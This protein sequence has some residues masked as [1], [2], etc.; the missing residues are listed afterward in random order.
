[1]KERG[2][3]LLSGECK[4]GY[5]IYRT[6]RTPENSYDAVHSRLCAEFPE[7][8]V[9]GLLGHYCSSKK[10]LPSNFDDWKDFFGR[11]YANL[12]VHYLQR[13]LQDS[14]FRSGLIPGVDVLRY[15]FNRRLKC[16]SET[17]PVEL[18]VTHSSDVPIWFWGANFSGGLTEQEKAWLK[19]WNQGFASFV[20]GEKVE[21]GPKQPKEMRWWRSD[22]ETDVWTD[23]RWEE[24]LKIWN[25]PNKS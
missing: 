7:D 6:W 24:G 25:L 4:D 12:Q 5:T 20:K 9:E 18:G 13:G 19:G 17:F 22:G 8:T 2:I 21:W 1:M 3:T 16:V 15:R 11:T 10:Q 23:D 14:L